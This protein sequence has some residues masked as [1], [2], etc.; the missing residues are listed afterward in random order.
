[1]LNDLAGAIAAF[2]T[3]IE[4][5]SM[6][7]NV[8]GMTFSE[9]GRRIAENGSAGTDHGTSSPHFLFGTGVVGGFAGPNPDFTHVDQTGDFIYDIDFRQFYATI[10][11]T[12]FGA[13]EEELQMVLYRHFDQLPVIRT[14]LT[15][16]SVSENQP[17]VF[18]LKQNYP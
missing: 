7:D 14:S 9:F 2:Q 16:T 17:T 1:L 4:L 18:R 5:L 3:D 11:G 10:L 13:P 6:A 8:V 12:W 15:P